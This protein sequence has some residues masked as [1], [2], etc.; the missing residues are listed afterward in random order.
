MAQA[1]ERLIEQAAAGDQVVVLFSGHGSQVPIR[2]EQTDAYDPANPEPD[3]LDEV[4]LPADADSS[5]SDTAVNVI[6]DNE[7]RRWLESFL[8]HPNRIVPPTEATCRITVVI[9]ISCPTIHV[10]GNLDGSD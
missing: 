2:D 9:A 4:F 8:A 3:G 5:E 7:F 6:R 1:V 10:I